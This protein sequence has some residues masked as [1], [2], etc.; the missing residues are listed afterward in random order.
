MRR[1][2]D[3]ASALMKADPLVLTQPDPPPI[4]GSSKCR[5]RSGV[6]GSTSGSPGSRWIEGGCGGETENLC[7]AVESLC[8]G[9]REGPSCRRGGVPYKGGEMVDSGERRSL[10]GQK[11]SSW[12]G[13]W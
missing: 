5:R 4:R 7:P 9:R 6:S 8:V 1:D 11:A 12:M 3:P 13:V 2:R 10:R